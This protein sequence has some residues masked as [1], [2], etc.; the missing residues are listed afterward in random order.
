MNS[1][2][3]YA[4]HGQQAGPVDPEALRSLIRQGVVHEETLIWRD[5]MPDWRPLAQVADAPRPLPAGAPGDP[6]LPTSDSPLGLPSAATAPDSLACAVCQRRFPAEDLITLGGRAVC[7][8][9]KPMAV[10]RLEEGLGWSGEDPRHQRPLPVDPDALI[11][12]IRSRDYDARLGPLLAKAW[13][14]YRTPGIFWPAIGAS[15]LILLIH[16]ASGMVPFVGALIALA[17][18]GPLY[19]GLYLW[20]LKHVRGGRPPV[21]EVF[22]GFSPDFVRYLLTGLLLVVPMLI[23]MI[24][25][26][27]PV[28][29]GVAFFSMNQGGSDGPPALMFIG[30]GLAVLVVVLVNLYF[31]VGFGFAV[32]LAADL[33]LGPLQAVWTSLRAVNLHFWRV[34]WLGI[35]GGIIAILGLLGLIIGVLFTIPI[36]LFLWMHLYEEIFALRSVPSANLSMNLSTQDPVVPP[37][38]ATGENPA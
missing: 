14:M 19:A 23:T 2:W 6:S 34:L 36:F 4:L 26:A 16:Q 11:E 21:A 29:I 8:D 22:S 24:L 5:G 25:V 12:E 33:K 30:I 27:I 10:Q 9:C 31:Q 15:A 32:P 35:V 13:A 28:G 17:L 20:Y 38:A 3:Y 7:G 18:Q 1:Q 37:P